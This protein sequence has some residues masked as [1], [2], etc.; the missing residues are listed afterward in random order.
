MLQYT[1]LNISLLIQS[2]LTIDKLIQ[3]TQIDS[4]LV[5]GI[6]GVLSDENVYRYLPFKSSPITHVTKFAFNMLNMSEIKA[7][8]VSR[9]SASKRVLEK[10]LI[11]M[12]SIVQLYILKRS[13]L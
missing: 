8:V 3:I 4:K 2:Y 5:T 11:L 13:K 12:V 9:N 1:R 6:K 7:S 10:S